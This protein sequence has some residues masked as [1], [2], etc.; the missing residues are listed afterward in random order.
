MRVVI[1]ALDGLDYYLAKKWNLKNILQAQSHIFKVDKQYFHEKEKVPY[2][3]MIWSSFL[4][5]LPPSKHGIKLWWEYH[6]LLE[7]IRYLPIIRHIRGKR[8]ILWKLRLKKRIAKVKTSTFLDSIN[9]K[10]VIWFP[11]YNDSTELHERLSRA[12]YKGLSEYEKEIWRVHRDRRAETFKQLKSNWTLFMTYFDLADLL[13]HIYL[14]KRILKLRIAYQHL[15]QIIYSMKQTINQNLGVE[16]YIFLIIA[17]HGM[18]M[19]GQHSDYAF[20]SLNFK[21]PEVHVDDFTKF[22]ELIKR[23]VNVL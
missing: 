10:K 8:R 16:N 21:S 19:N 1:V 23:W 6:P 3:P 4:T 14:P 13:G 11:N 2:S 20:Y 18:N 5:G 7:K 22:K 15:D 9:N 12:F 17:D